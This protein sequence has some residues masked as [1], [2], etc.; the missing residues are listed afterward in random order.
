MV[1]IL[2]SCLWVCAVVQVSSRRCKWMQMRWEW[3]NWCKVKY[4]KNKI[5]GMNTLMNS[6]IMTQ[7]S[8]Y[9]PRCLRQTST[10]AAPAPAIMGGRVETWWRISSAS[11]RMAGRGRRATPVRAAPTFSTPAPSAR[12]GSRY[13]RTAV[14]NYY[15]S[16]AE[17]GSNRL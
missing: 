9:L 6:L 17:A 7:K 16:S 15:D 10:T 2:L 12:A 4:V 11:A 14:Q 5:K 13:A 3:P 1:W 8:P